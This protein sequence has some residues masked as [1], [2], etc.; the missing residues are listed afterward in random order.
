M[1]NWILV[2]VLAL[3]PFALKAEE[4]AKVVEHAYSLIDADK[5]KNLYDTNA[6]MVVLDARTGHYFDGTTLPNAKWIT[7][8]STE[9]AILAAAPK[10]DG[11]V[12]VYCTSTQCPAGGW[13]ADKLVAM[14]YTNVNKYAGGV[15]DWAAKGLPT[16]KQ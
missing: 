5:V 2:F 14:G 3:S 6:E 1:K 7:A 11:L 8:E 4:S 12:I 16:V 9:E 10:K 13:L 15:Q